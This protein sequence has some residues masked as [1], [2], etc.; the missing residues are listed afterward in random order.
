MNNHLLAQ[1]QSQKSLKSKHNL[2][3]DKKLPLFDAVTELT[4][5]EM[6]DQ[7]NVADKTEVSKLL[8]WLFGQLNQTLKESIK[9]MSGRTNRNLN[10]LDIKQ[11]KKMFE[12]VLRS[13]TLPE[14][15]QEKL[16]VMC[17]VLK[18]LQ[19]LYKEAATC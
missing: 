16:L 12:V 9:Y 10:G 17:D 2:L 7:L 13:G 11:V 6:E 19:S 18:K 4:K 1:N 3:F 8:T 5:R 14:T 15:L